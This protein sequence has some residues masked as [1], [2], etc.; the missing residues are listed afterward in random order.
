MM[1]IEL[2]IIDHVKIVNI[3]RISQLYSENLSTIRYVTIELS[4]FEHVLHYDNNYG[5]HFSRHPK[6][7]TNIPFVKIPSILKIHFDSK[8]SVTNGSSR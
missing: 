8:V 5:V 7:N 3:L 1:M 6:H 2:K 4:C